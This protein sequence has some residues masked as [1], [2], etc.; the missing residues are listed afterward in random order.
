[1]YHYRSHC[2]VTTS[3]HYAGVWLST[4]MKQF[5]LIRLKLDLFFCYYCY[6]MLN[7][8]LHAYKMKINVNYANT[9]LEAICSNDIELNNKQ[10]PTERRHHSSTWA[11]YCRTWYCF[12]IVTITVIST[13]L[14][15][16]CCAWSCVGSHPSTTRYVTK[17]L[18][19]LCP[20]AIDCNKNCQ[21]KST[22]SITLV[23]V[24]DNI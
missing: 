23:C 22:C 8:F 19:P 17:S 2:S 21:V 11:R 15:F 13:V 18:G 3:V 6:N 24:L 7:S 1:M 20:S 9:Q 16:W 4:D 5:N 14:W 12:F 10:W